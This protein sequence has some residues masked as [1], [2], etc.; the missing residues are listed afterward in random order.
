MYE[1]QLREDKHLEKKKRLLEEREVS[2]GERET[3]LVAIFKEPWSSKHAQLVKFRRE[4][5][6]GKLQSSI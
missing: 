1:A 4:N 5:E 3:S 6:V 2:K